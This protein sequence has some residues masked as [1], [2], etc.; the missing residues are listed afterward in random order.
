MSQKPDFTLNLDVGSSDNLS[1]DAIAHAPRN[2]RP[3]D[4]IGACNNLRLEPQEKDIPPAVLALARY[5][6]IDFFGLAHSTGLYN[7]QIKLWEA[8]SKIKRVEIYAARKGFINKVKLPEFDMVLLDQRSRILVAAHYA[9]PSE[10]EPAYDYLKSTKGF[11]RRAALREGIRGLFL[12]YPSPFPKNV[13]EFVLKETGAQDPLSYYE[14]TLPK[15][16]APINLLEIEEGAESAQADH[17]LQK[18]RLVHPRLNSRTA[19][20]S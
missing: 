18:I 19:I 14:S 3:Q 8:V 2:F 6:S 1:P 17:R 20:Q 9:Q 12:C 7:R 5:I 15:L 4:V 13:L 11:L 16:G 10:A